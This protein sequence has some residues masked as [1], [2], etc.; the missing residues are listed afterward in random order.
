MEKIRF[1]I[2]KGVFGESRVEGLEGLEYFDHEAAAAEFPQFRLGPSEAA[3]RFD[4]GYVIECSEALLEL[5]KQASRRCTL[6]LDEE[7]N[8][9]SVEEKEESFPVLLNRSATDVWTKNSLC[10]LTFQ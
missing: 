2:I 10:D 3:F 1:L 5:Q 9:T 8:E 4:E 6:H 7:G